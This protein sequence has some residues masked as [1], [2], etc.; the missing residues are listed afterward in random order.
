MGAMFPPLG[1]RSA[2]KPQQL[3]PER[4][5]PVFAIEEPVSVAT[6]VVFA[7]PH[8][9]RR[10]PAAWLARSI[11]QPMD[12]RRVEDAFVDRL[13][14]D[15]PLTGS[16]L[17]H[18]LIGRA[19]LDLNRAET[20]LDAA[21]FSDPPPS[22]SA[23]RSPRV[24]AGLGCIPRVAHNGAAIYA[25]KLTRREAELRIE[26]VYRPYHRAL[27]SLLDRAHATFGEAWL[28]D[29]H[30]M[31][32]EAEA[33]NLP[34]VV[35]GDRYGASCAPE[36]VRHVEGLFRDKGYRTA[37]NAPYAGGHA[38]IAYGRP[39]QGRHALQIELRRGL[40]MD[41]HVVEPTADFAALRRDI[42]DIA[43]D[44]CAFAQGKIALR[45]GYIKKKVAP[46][47]GATKVLGRKRP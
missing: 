33:A 29:C 23:R 9:G 24:E 21:M 1:F 16:P 17:I 7:S 8:S 10:Y 26:A 46:A 14:A 47:S 38:T 25:G 37:R 39:S 13:F 34:D 6:P 31:P 28:I 4:L 30:S 43:A 32:S 22:W 5:G 44:L 35:I 18:G 42:A 27:G 15:A 40:Y 19:V 36:I 45:Y 3:S 12:L 20:E 11:A 41:E 2:A